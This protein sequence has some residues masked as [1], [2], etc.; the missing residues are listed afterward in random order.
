[1]R[2]ILFRGK[3]DANIDKADEKNYHFIVTYDGITLRVYSNVVGNI[4]D[5]PELVEVEK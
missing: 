4:H 3:V 2:E 5:N 1:M